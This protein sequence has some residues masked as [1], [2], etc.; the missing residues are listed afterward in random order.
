MYASHLSR[1]LINRSNRRRF[2]AARCLGSIGRGRICS[3]WAATRWVVDACSALGVKKRNAQL[4]LGY[5]FMNSPDRI[6]LVVSHNQEASDA[7]LRIVD[8]FEAQGCSAWADVKAFYSPLVSAERQVAKAFSNARV[9]CLFVDD[10]YRDTRWCQEEYGLGLR[11]EQDLSINRVITIHHGESARALIPSALVDKP[12][13]PFTEAGCRGIV[14]F[15]LGL[16][17]HSAALARWTK[18]AAT[19]KGDLLGRLPVSERTKLIVEH[20]EFLVRHFAMGQF[21][22]GSDRHALRLGLVGTSPSRTPVHLTPALLMELAWNSANEVLG[23]YS[24]R[25]LTD[26]TTH[27]EAQDLDPETLLPFLRLP[28]LFQQYLGVARA[29]RSPPILTEIELRSVV[30]HVL[31]G[32]A[33]LCARAGVEVDEAFRDVGQLLSLFAESEPGVSRAAAYL[34]EHLPEIAYPENSAQ[35]RASIY[36]LLWAS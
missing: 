26:S 3:R 29:R 19:A 32:F 17:D 28:T 13:F 5:E 21:E 22:S 4:S 9:I 2:A 7:A 27:T 35:R 30:D 12:T 8:W 36:S 16:P 20:V 14:E 6:D 33:L 23:K 1:R 25:R 11:A 31:C 15:L 18:S 24:V 34:R 10:R